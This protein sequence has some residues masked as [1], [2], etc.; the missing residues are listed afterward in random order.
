[1]KFCNFFPACSKN[2]LGVW[3]NIFNGIKCKII[4]LVVR[5]GVIWVRLIP[6]S[7]IPIIILRRV[8]IKLFLRWP[9]A[10]LD[11]KNRSVE[12]GQTHILREVVFHA[13]TKCSAY[14]II[15]KKYDWLFIFY[16]LWVDDGRLLLAV[17]KL[18]ELGLL[19]A[20]N[21]VFNE[22]FAEVE[23]IE[24]VLYIGYNH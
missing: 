14:R 24:V 22:Y 1:M 12:F 11:L 16:L 7:R 3:K 20:H 21:L 18:S 9:T 4:I 2:C 19:G 23:Q 8:R 5:I 6:I 15:G 17:Q 10:V 13:N